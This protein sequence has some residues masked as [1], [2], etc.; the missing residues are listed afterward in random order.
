MRAH[1]YLCLPHMESDWS[2][3]SILGLLQP[4]SGCG[5]CGVASLTSATLSSLVVRGYS[6]LPPPE[7]ME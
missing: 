2:T 3:P 7:A 4:P 6:L 5:I 1:R